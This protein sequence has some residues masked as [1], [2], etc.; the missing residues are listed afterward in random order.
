MAT[1]VAIMDGPSFGANT[2]VLAVVDSR[3]EQI[4][5]V[6]R[7]L[8]CESLGDRV[9][10]AFS[11]GGHEPLVAALA[12]H[13]LAVEHSLCL[14]PAAIA[15]GFE[16]LETEVPVDC[17]LAFW[18]PLRRGRPIEE[19][20]RL[21]VFE[22]PAE[23]LSG[24]RLHEWIGARFARVGSGSDLGRIERQQ[25]LVRALLKDGVDFA[26]FLTHPDSVAASSSEAIAELSEITAEWQ[27][28]TLPGIRPAR[29][30]GRDVLV[31]D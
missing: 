23:R 10:A 21:V 30:G 5:S 25:A 7:D 8:W 22:P 6:P 13:G 2:D 19:G 14:L 24:K 16:D 1:A 9:N 3:L 27:L 31:R 26:R 15:A 4:L 28:A 18:Y 20:R 17:F 29:I 12:E 11:R